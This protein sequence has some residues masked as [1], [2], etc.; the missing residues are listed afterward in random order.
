MNSWIGIG[1]LTADPELRY[2]QSN[3]AVCR[4]AL[5]VDRPFRQGEQKQAD[6]IRITVF[7]KQAENCGR[8]LAKGRQ[9]GRAHV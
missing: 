5:A 9:I 4:F 2:T 6:F 8:Y 7:G 3:T 1:R